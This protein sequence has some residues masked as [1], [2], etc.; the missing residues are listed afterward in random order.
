[1]LGPKSLITVAY[2]DI[3]LIRYPPEALTLRVHLSVTVAPSE[4]AVGP[5]FELRYSP[6]IG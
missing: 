4:S 5:D 3:A 6:S 1:M 2:I